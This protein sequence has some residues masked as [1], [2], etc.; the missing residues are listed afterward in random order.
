MAV[1]WVLKVVPERAPHSG[2]L[3]YP[4]CVPFPKLKRI[5]R[6]ELAFWTATLPE[7]NSSVEW[8]NAGMDRVSTNSRMDSSE[9]DSSESPNGGIPSPVEKAM[10]PVLDRLMSFDTSLKASMPRLMPASNESS[11]PIDGQGLRVPVEGMI[12]GPMDKPVSPEETSALESQPS[13]RLSDVSSSRPLLPNES[14]SSL[15]V[16]RSTSARTRDDSLS[17]RMSTIQSDVGERLSPTVT[18]SPQHDLESTSSSSTPKPPN[19]TA[20]ETLKP[21]AAPGQ[22]NSCPALPVSSMATEDSKDTSKPAA[23]EVAKRPL[24]VLVVDDD[25][26]TR[27]L[28]SRMLQR[29]GCNIS[30]AEDG[31]HAL[32][33]LLDPE[34]HYFDCVF[35]DNQVSYFLLFSNVSTILIRSCFLDAP[36][37]WSRCCARASCGGPY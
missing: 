19:T 24:N 21:P 22:S 30:T 36:Q 27:K 12:V 25:G 20:S 34:P 16:P 33:L 32:D 23:E 26:L 15:S 37:D 1:E 29:Q 9:G 13:T 10:R 35:L 6:F 11:R 5:R 18:A 8:K 4:S 2:K 31:Q 28:M 3:R 17:Q 7:I 14:T